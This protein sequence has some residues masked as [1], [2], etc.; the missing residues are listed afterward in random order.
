MPTW[1]LRPIEKKNIEEKSFFT[2]DDQTICRIEWYRWAS[3]KLESDQRPDIDLDNP[4][5]YDVYGSGLDWDLLDMTDGVSVEWEFPNDMDEE[6]R[7][8]IE[9]IYADDGYSGLEEVGWDNIDT[10]VFIYGPLELTS[11]ID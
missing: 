7:I 9:E 6:E 1:T 2:K 3:W 10:E 8:R 4:D 5:G 11:D